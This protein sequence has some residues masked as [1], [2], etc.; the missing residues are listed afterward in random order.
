MK[1]TVVEDTD[2][3][4]PYYLGLS[5]VSHM[6]PVEVVLSNS[7][8]VEKRTGVYL[9]NQMALVVKGHDIINRWIA[10]KARVQK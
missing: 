3:S 7:A 5:E 10:Y 8:R 6:K 9:N 4:S 1:V 2:R